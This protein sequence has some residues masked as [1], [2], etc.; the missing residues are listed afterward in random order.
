[1]DGFCDENE[2]PFE[3]FIPPPPIPA[4]LREELGLAA[5]DSV[6]SSVLSSS[7]LSSP[8]EHGLEQHPL[9]S[10]DVDSS[11]QHGYCHFCKWA[12]PSYDDWSIPGTIGKLF[13][14]LYF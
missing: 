5:E 9:L 3:F 12:D 11:S 2:Y 7:N 13:F 10:V 14:L 6:D 8:S 4:F 1:M